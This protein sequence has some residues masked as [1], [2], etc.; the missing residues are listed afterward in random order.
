MGSHSK[1]IHEYVSAILKEQLKTKD[2][3]SSRL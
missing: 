3:M 2:K 1:F